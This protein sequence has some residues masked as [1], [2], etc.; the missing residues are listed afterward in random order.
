MKIEERQG[1]RG[2]RGLQA[3]EAATLVRDHKGGS[4]KTV[5]R[6]SEAPRLG[7]E[8]S[9]IVILFALL[10][11]AVLFIALTGV[12]LVSIAWTHRPD[13]SVFDI[14][15]EAVQEIRKTI[16]KADREKPGSGKESERSL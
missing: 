12:L 10:C 13:L 4:G 7:K 2:L 5:Y 14:L 1:F 11:V 3:F 9:K 6:A 15:R 8:G 16:T